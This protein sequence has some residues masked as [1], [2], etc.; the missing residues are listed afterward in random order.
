MSINDNR[1]TA[2]QVNTFI[3]CAF[4]SLRFCPF[5]MGERMSDEVQNKA[6]WWRLSEDWLSVTVALV[7]IGLVASGVIAGVPW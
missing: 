5:Y 6:P 7:L 3:L 1:Y 4:A 2:L